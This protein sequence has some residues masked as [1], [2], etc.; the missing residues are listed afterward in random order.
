MIIMFS[1]SFMVIS[2]SAINNCSSF[3]FFIRTHSANE[4]IK[5]TI[6][7]TCALITK[8]YSLLND[9]LLTLLLPNYIDESEPTSIYRIRK[10]KTWSFIMELPKPRKIKINIIISALYDSLKL[11][12]VTQGNVWHVW[13]RSYLLSSLLTDG[14]E[15]E[16][17]A[18]GE[19]AHW[20]MK[21]WV[22]S[23]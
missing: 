18:K 11:S 8:L 6:K 16:N 2:A 12:R 15:E 5:I 14:E 10:T 1:V 7:L 19:G 3:C 13:G 4:N 21:A 17:E 9:R 23:F 22:L 20:M